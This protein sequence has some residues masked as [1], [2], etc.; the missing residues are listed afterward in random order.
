[1][2]IYLPTGY[3]LY[4]GEVQAMFRT[5]RVEMVKVDLERLAGLTILD[6][7]GEE[8]VV[9][10]G[11]GLLVTPDVGVMVPDH[12]FHLLHGAM[13]DE[14]GSDCG[15]RLALVVE[16]EDQGSLFVGNDHMKA[17]HRW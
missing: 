8:Y 5:E 1:M 12:P 2:L 6:A 14:V 10:G 13:M 4:L 9:G 15:G 3:L 16:V 17:P 11:Y 7:R